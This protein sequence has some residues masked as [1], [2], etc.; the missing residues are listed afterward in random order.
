MTKR[1]LS[2][3][4]KQFRQLLMANFEVYR[5][6]QSLRTFCTD[7][8]HQQLILPSPLPTSHVVDEPLEFFEANIEYVASWSEA[9]GRSNSCPHWKEDLKAKK[10]SSNFCTVVVP[11]QQCDPSLI[12]EPD[13]SGVLP[14]FYVSLPL[15]LSSMLLPFPL[16]F[17]VPSPVFF[18]LPP[19]PLF[20]FSAPPVGALLPPGILPL[21]SA[22]FF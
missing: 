9:E 12:D 7:I 4:R 10:S 18:S 20:L 13:L 8:L 2:K 14:L 15:L 21:P 16:V 5:V 17:A 22:F 1:E 6:F 3:E 11:R 19:S